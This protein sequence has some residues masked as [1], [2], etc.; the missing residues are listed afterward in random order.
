M[1][2]AN[3]R[4]GVMGSILEESDDTGT[5]FEDDV[6]TKSGMR[7]SI[8]SRGNRDSF[9]NAISSNNLSATTVRCKRMVPP[10]SS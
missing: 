5:N 4:E 10:S 2:Q 7:E 6:S 1:E 8:G 3:S 9:S